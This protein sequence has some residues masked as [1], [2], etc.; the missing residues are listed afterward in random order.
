MAA[1]LGERYN[2][3]VVGCDP[4]ADCTTLL[5]DDE[6]IPTVLELLKEKKD[7][8]IDDFIVKGYNGVY[9][10]ESGGPK[11]GVGCAGR[12][13]I[14][15][16][17]L[18]KKLNV[19]KKLDIDIVIYDVLGDVV[20]GGFAVPLRELSEV[21]IVT[22]SDYMALYAANNICR[23]IREINK[24]KLGGI[25]YNV[26]GAFDYYDIVEEFSK[27]INSKI[28]GKIPNSS[29]IVKAELYGKTV[30]E[31]YPDSEITKKY[32]ELAKNIINNRDYTLPNPLTNKELKTISKKIKEKI[33]SH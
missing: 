29:L 11:P 17:N 18:L 3:L 16:N 31:L 23:G 15:V 21:Y 10:V 13:I 33:S 1:V 6:E 22:S 5:R 30:I 2:V 12:G 24:A 9:C 7:I 28:I 32:E 20:C 4:K 8:D 26:R 19:F 27:K 14:A 25:I